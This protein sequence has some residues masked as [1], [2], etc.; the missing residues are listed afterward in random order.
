MRNQKFR[1]HVHL[2]TIKR[3]NSPKFTEILIVPSNPQYALI[4]GSKE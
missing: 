4:E 2:A 1:G 3:A